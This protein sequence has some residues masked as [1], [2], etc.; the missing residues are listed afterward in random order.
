MGI[1][2]TWYNEL[3]SIMTIFG[4]GGSIYGTYNTASGNASGNYSLVGQIDTAGS[5]SSATGWTVAWNNQ[6][7][8]SRSAT[9]WTGLYQNGSFGTEEI[10][11]LWHLATEMPEPDQWK[12]VHVG[13][14]TFTRGKPSAETVAQRQAR[15]MA[16]HPIMAKSK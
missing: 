1:Q 8:S 16:S 6:H 12:A 9:S 7:G 14:D 5:G 3:G 10:Y 4:S 15:G 13:Q 11:T 2:G